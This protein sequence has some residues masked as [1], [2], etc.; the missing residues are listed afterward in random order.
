MQKIKA[1]KHTRFIAVHFQY[2]SYVHLQALQI[3]T[4]MKKRNYKKI[5]NASLS[6]FLSAFFY[7]SQLHTQT[8][9]VN[10]L[11]YNKIRVTK[12]HV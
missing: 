11:K 10:Y 6:R 2:E 4:M 5:T 12:L 8:H 1:Q 3:F 7:L 9:Q